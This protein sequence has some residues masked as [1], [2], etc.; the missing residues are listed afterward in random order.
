M[1]LGLFALLFVISLSAYHWSAKSGQPVVEKESVYTWHKYNEAGDQELF[2]A[3]T[4][5]GTAQEAEDEFECPQGEAV[6]CARAYDGMTP[7]DI[8]VRKTNP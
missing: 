7:L 6:I 3:V 8:Y 4:F 5:V 2:P 1:L